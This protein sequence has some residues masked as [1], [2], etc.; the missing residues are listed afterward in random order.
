MQITEQDF[1]DC[2]SISVDISYVQPI[3]RMCSDKD[4]KMLIKE[5][6]CNNEAQANELF[7]QLLS[8]WDEAKH[9]T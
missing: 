2:K 4:N 9:E 6:K 3:I 5:I 7:E 1:I 8:A